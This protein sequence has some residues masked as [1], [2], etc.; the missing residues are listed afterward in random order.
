M[1]T[2]TAEEFL[3]E[4]WPNVIERLEILESRSVEVHNF[5]FAD[6][7]E[8]PSFQ[9]IAFKIDRHVNVLCDWANFIKKILKG[10]AY[11]LKWVAIIL[12]S[13]FAIWG[14]LHTVG[15]TYAQ[16][17]TGINEQGS[18]ADYLRT[19]LASR[20]PSQV[21]VLMFFGGVGIAANWGWKW[22][23]NQIDGSLWHYLFL[24]HPRRSLASLSAYVGWIFAVAFPSDMVSDTSTWTAVINLALTTGFTIDVI[25]NKATM[26]GTANGTDTAT[27]KV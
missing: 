8:R 14:M 19:L 10:T 12:T 24:D 22:M 25:A 21:A 2:K 15:L 5:I 27:P 3:T 18:F 16:A 11:G 1:G 13:I 26:K 7:E 17:A 4:A 20:R 6:T 23:S 9:T